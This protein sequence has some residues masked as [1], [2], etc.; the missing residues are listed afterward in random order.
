MYSERVCELDHFMKLVMIK[1]TFGATKLD[2]NKNI[3]TNKQY[4]YKYQI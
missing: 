1:C 4:Y 3:N 2:A